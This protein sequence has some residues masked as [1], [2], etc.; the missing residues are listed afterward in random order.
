MTATQTKQLKPG[1]SVRYHG[2]RTDRHGVYTLVGDCPCD[3]KYV[4][5]EHGGIYYCGELGGHELVDQDGRTLIHVSD[6]SFT[7]A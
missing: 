3:N 4:T 2:S 6:T 7:A 1:T 5:P